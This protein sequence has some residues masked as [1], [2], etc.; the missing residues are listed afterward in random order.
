MAMK[1]LKAVPEELT[2]IVSDPKGWELGFVRDVD[3][4]DLDLAIP[5]TLNCRSTLPSGRRSGTVGGTGST[6]R[7]RNTADCWRSSRHLLKTTVLHGEGIPGEGCPV[8]N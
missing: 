4:I 3:S 1:D 7:G 2:F 8:K 5:T 6:F